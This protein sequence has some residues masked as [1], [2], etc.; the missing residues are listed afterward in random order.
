MSTYPLLPTEP[1]FPDPDSITHWTCPALPQ[2]DRDGKPLNNNTHHMNNFNRCKY[3]HQEAGVLRLT[4][5]SEL[6][7]IREEGA[8]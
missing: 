8:R 4:Q 2:R 5:A 1:V 7:R 3:C 6:A